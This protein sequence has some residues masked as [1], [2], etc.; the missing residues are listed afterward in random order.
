MKSS[1]L[2]AVKMKT[3]LDVWKIPCQLSALDETPSP[4]APG[5]QLNSS[6]IPQAL[7]SLAS[8]EREHSNPHR[9]IRPSQMPP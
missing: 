1:F 6:K 8:A 4:V 2:A 5:S 3:D 9:M 7:P